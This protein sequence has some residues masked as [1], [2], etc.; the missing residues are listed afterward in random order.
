[1][2]DRVR[3]LL[4]AVAVGVAAAVLLGTGPAAQAAG[5]HRATPKTPPAG[6][7]IT[8]VGLT[9]PL[10]LRTDTAPTHVVAVIDQVSWFG[11]TGEAKGPKAADLGPK[12]TIVVLAGDAP[13]QTFDLYPLAKGGPRAFRPAKQPDQRKTTAGWF[14]GRLTMSETL[15]AAGVP[16]EPQLDTVSGGVG[17]G[18]R[19]LSDDVLNPGRDIDD[20]IAELQ[21]LLLLNVGVMLVITLGLA[22]IALLVRRRTR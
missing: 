19:T 20:A 21:R 7:D 4:A 14:L 16:L 5:A 10:R 11:R 12:Y 1:M 15:R 9:E 22:G 13:R 3:R 17:G 6:V 18:E 2:V 8:G